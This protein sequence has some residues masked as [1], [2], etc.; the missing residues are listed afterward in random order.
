MATTHS[1]TNIS[2]NYDSG[3]ISLPFLSHEG[4]SPFNVDIKYGSVPAFLETPAE[5]NPFFEISTNEFLLKIPDIGN[6]YVANG[7]QII[8]EK[9]KNRSHNEIL[10]FLMD[11]VFAVL[12]HQKSL[13]SF[14]GTALEKDGE[15][16]LL[17]GSDGSGKSTLARELL[18]H[19]DC[20]L[21][22]DGHVFSDGISFFSGFR[23]LTLWQ[24]IA[25]YYGYDLQNLIQPRPGLNKFWLETNKTTKK[26]TTEISA[27]YHLT[28]NKKQ[29]YNAT[30]INGAQKLTYLWNN[31]S[32]RRL[33]ELMERKK[34]N[35]GVLAQLAGK[36]TMKE[37]AFYPKVEK[38]MDPGEL[39]QIIIN[40]FKK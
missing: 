37:L 28:K 22:A 19:D 5:K 23:M 20:N 38:E 14:R 15:G 24:D 9:A 21:I 12:V 25:E 27:V 30:E 33:A 3:N 6:F 26:Q 36:T 17:A 16:I 34:K 18:S 32:Y 13:L 39:A 35:F 11:S 4:L 1:N 2:E 40:D 31:T 7:E 29:E 10:L 8:V